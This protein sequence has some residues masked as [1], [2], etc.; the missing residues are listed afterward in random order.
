MGDEKSE[1]TKQKPSMLPLQNKKG[2]VDQGRAERHYEGN[3]STS[4]PGTVAEEC[5]DAAQY[6]VYGANENIPRLQRFRS[7]WILCRRVRPVV[8]VLRGPMP[9]R[10]VKSQE[11]RARLLSLYLR[12]WVMQET[13]ATIYV[14]HI[15][16]LDAVRLHAKG[17]ATYPHPVKRH[18]LTRR[19]TPSEV[20]WAT[21]SYAR[22]WQNYIRGNVVSEYSACLIQ[23]FLTIMSG[24]GTG[25]R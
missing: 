3:E 25:A 21:R 17:E 7:K 8:P 24:T 11:Q 13:E 5:T 22:A 2:A 18:R 16:D 15:R 12:P 10:G 4:M 1:N 19:T 23:S 9:H 20:P 6:A 14:P